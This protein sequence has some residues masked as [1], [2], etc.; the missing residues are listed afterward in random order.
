M[1]AFTE[2][3]IKI[4]Q[5]IPMGKVMT[6]GQIATAAGKKNGARRIAW[7]L[8]SMSRKYHLP[9]HRVINAKGEISHTGSEQ[10]ELLEMEGVQ[11][12]VSGKV[13]LT[14]YRYYPSLSITETEQDNPDH[15]NSNHDILPGG[16]DLLQKDSRQND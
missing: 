3:A 8:S 2:A 13:D 11:F 4:I 7:I 1:E 16:H 9:W 14:V 6:Y 12:G 15:D 10:R 5:S